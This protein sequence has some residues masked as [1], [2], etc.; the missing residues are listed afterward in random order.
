MAFVCPRCGRS[1]AN[2]NDEREGYC[3]A[4]RDWTGEP[5]GGS[6]RRTDPDTVR[7]WHD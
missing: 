3:G 7:R 2:P 4:C 1:S 6:G 5:A